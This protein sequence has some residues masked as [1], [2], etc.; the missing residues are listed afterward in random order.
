M[1]CLNYLQTYQNIPYKIFYNALKDGKIFHAYLFV[2][3]MGTPLLD[4]AKYLAANIILNDNEPFNIKNESAF[5][6]II[7]NNFGDLIILDTKS[8]PVKIDDIRNLEDRFSKTSSESFGKKVYI[9]N[10]VENLGIDSTNALLKFLEEPNEDTYGILITEN[11]SAL[12]P[13]IKSRVQTIHFSKI[14]Q[15]ILIEKAVNLGSN[16][17]NAELLSFFYNDEHS[18]LE[19]QQD[20]NFIA[21]Q[22][23]ALE[24]LS[25]INNYNELM[26]S[27]YNNVIKIIKDKISARMYFDFIIT[28]FKEALKYK[29]NKDTILKNYDNIL[30]DLARLDS[31]ENSI[32]VFMNSRNEISYNLNLNL[33]IVHTFES[34]FGDKKWITI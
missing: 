10:G 32:L 19:A 12:L 14:N 31:L 20:K 27:I 15:D 24:T 28:F 2:G 11:E 13:T 23:I 3:E 8:D 33:L 1:N 25:H 6:R 18:I 17:E 7:S 22:E 16:L 5:N 9:I 30:K 21:I 26:N 29:Y 4:I 34:V